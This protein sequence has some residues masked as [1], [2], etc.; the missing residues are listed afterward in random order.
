M[1][2]R[3]TLSD[4]SNLKSRYQL[5]FPDIEPS[6]NI[7]PGQEILVII[8]KDVPHVTL[9]RWGLIP[10]WSKEKTAGMINARA[11]TVEQK[12]TFKH[13]FIKQRCLIPADGFFEWKKGKPRKKPYRFIMK[14]EKVFSFAGLW[15]AWTFPEGKTIY[16]CAIITTAANELIEPIHN[17]MPVILS[18]EAEKAWLSK[19]AGVQTLKGLLKPYPSELMDSYEVADL[20]NSPRNNTPQV[21][22]PV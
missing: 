12:P 22:K 4:I 14:D 1:C 8:R 5:D 13:S 7:A 20:V 19:D 6:Y 15:D 17:R 9:L 21:I 16:S 3:F 18:P 11:E 2:G 10:F